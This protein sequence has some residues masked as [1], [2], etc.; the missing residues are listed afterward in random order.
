[1]A[2]VWVIEKRSREDMATMLMGNFPVRAFA[3]F[4]SFQKLVKL[5]ATVKPDFLIIDA[6]AFAFKLDSSFEL[7]TYH[8]PHTKVIVTSFSDNIKVPEA[9]FFIKKPVEPIYLTR[10][11]RNLHSTKQERPNSLY[12]KDLVFD[13]DRFE[14]S[15]AGADAQEKLPMKEAQIL[16]LLIENQ[17]QCL[18][19]EKIKHEVWSEVSVSSRTIDSHISRLRKRLSSAKIDIEGVYGGGYLLK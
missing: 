12:F 7:I 9:S 8:L 13:K 18:T 17:G 15:T 16:K 11:L 6:D 3:S 19:R 4:D 10:I 5:N 14:I 1:M 2:I